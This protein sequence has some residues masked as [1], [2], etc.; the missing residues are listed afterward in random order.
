MKNRE[1][2]PNTDDALKAFE[3]HNKHC[4]CGATFEEWLDIDPDEVPVGLKF[5]AF[6]LA[7]LSR[8]A[9]DEKKDA[10]RKPET[11]GDEKKPEDAGDIECPFCHG[12]HG[13]IDLNFLPS[14]CCP[15]CGA[16]IGKKNCFDGN[17]FKAWFNKHTAAK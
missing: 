12:K 7:L 2:Y 16:I 8:I 14:F 4:K 5:A 1:R 15:D 11:S 10:E 9:K 13:R 6:G 17:E 3:E